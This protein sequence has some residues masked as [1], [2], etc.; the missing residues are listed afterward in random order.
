MKRNLYT[1]IHGNG[2]FDRNKAMKWA[3]QIRKSR[4]PF[5]LAIRSMLPKEGKRQGYVMPQTAEI[6]KSQIKHWRNDFKIMMGKGHTYTVLRREFRGEI[7]EAELHGDNARARALKEINDA[8]RERRR[9]NKQIN[10]PIYHRKPN[11][12]LAEFQGKRLKM[13][14]RPIDEA[15]YIGIEIE[16]IIPSHL[17]LTALIPFGKYIEVGGDGS[18]D[19]HGD[20]QGTEVRVCMRR[21]EVREVLPNLMQTLRG[22]GARINKSCGLHVHL[23]QRNNAEP[24]KVFQRLVRS[25]GL[26]YTVVPQSRRRNNYCK[27]NRHADFSMAVHGGRYKAVN[28]SAFHRYKTIEVRLFGGT[29]EA[30]KIINWIEVLTAIANGETV[31]RC[32]KTFDTALKYWKL[33]AQNLAW[34]KARQTQFSELNTGMP[35]SEHETE[36]NQALLDEDQDDEDEDCDCGDCE[37]CGYADEERE[38]A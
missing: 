2:I 4:E 28:A 13:P 1:V 29:L 23:D 16:C 20:E 22:M 15:E 18:I 17:D 38:A 37:S 9:R 27:R 26:L 10:D 8:I 31:M 6:L 7:I 34:L 35:V 32:P 25:L 30:T 3:S 21:D 19:H 11:G 33:S 12:L 36:A 14:K 5:A 24:E